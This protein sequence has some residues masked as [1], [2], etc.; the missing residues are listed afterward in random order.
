MPETG[1]SVEAVSYRVGD[2]P[3]PLPGLAVVGVKLLGLYALIHAIPQVFS[4]PLYLGPSALWSPYAL[5]GML[6]MAT[7]VAIGLML[8]WQA[9][10]VVRRVARIPMGETA[11]VT[12]NEH[13]QGVAFSVVGVVLI[14]WALADLAEQIAQ[15]AY[16]E[17]NRN[18]GAVLPAM[19]YT[20]VVEPLV[21]LAA[22]VVLFL[23]GRG[24]AALWHRMRYGGVRVRD[25]S[26]E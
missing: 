2:T 14:S 16:I 21:E 9:E 26:A 18:S 17:A 6:P 24:L 3:V 19:G 13:F 5:L 1:S 10:W 20:G 25:A 8:L 12:F 7:Y 4:F 23:R 11:P 15:F 22:G